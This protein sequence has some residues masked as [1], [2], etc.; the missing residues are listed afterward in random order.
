MKVVLLD[1]DNL[2]E[3]ELELNFADESLAENERLISAVVRWQLMNRRGFSSAKTK[4]VDE[5]AYT[6][7]KAYKQKGRGASRHGSLKR[8]QFVGGAKAFGPK[9]RD[10]SYVMPKKAI[11]KALRIVLKDKFSNGS[12]Y[13][14]NNLDKIPISTNSLNKKFLSKGISN[15]LVSCLDNVENFSKSVRNIKGVKLLDFN[16]LNVYDILNHS[17]LLVDKNAYN[18]IVNEVL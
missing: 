18:K 3:D 4:S 15:S 9:P 12:V 11:K 16:A 14:L 13:V 7:K 17:F 2:K 8:A 5:I 10:Y 1:I 6:G